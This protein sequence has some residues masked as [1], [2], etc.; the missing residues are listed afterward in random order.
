MYLALPAVPISVSGRLAMLALDPFFNQLNHAVLHAELYCG[1][2]V[3]AANQQH[4]HKRFHEVM[5]REH[6][7]VICLAEFALCL[8]LGGRMALG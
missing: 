3:E 2:A 1:F 6:L 8:S 4:E 7:P 5:K